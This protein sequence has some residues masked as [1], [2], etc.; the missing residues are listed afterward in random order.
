MTDNNTAVGVDALSSITSGT[1]NTSLGAE[2]LTGTSSGSENVAIGSQAGINNVS[3]SENVII[4]YGSAPTLTSGSSNIIIGAAADVPTASTSNYLN[5]GGV[6]T[7]DMSTGAVTLAD[8]FM[9]TT[10]SPLD[11]STKIATTAYVDDAVGASGTVTSVAA[12][13]TQGVTISGSPITSSGTITVGLGNITPT[14]VAASGTVT[15]SNLSG[16]NT[17]DQTITLTS[18]VTGSG[19][20]SFAT[21]IKSSVNLSGSPTTT[22]QSPLDDSTKIATTA[23]VDSAVA[24]GPGGTVTTTGSPSSGNLTKFSGPTSVTNGDLSGD[25][26]TSGTLATT[27]AAIQGTTVSGTTGTSKVVFSNSPTLVTPALGTPSSG[28][29]TNC[30]SLPVSTGISGL[31]AGVA[32]FLATPSSANLAAAVTGE[33]GSGGLVF[34]NS[35]SL[36]GAPTAPTQSPGD[37]STKI[38]TTAYVN[39]AVS[40]PKQRTIGFSAISPI[41]GQQGTFVVFPAIGTITGWSIVADAGT[42]TVKT[43]KIAAGTTAPTSANNIS[44]S[45]VSLATGTAV[46]S[47]IVT[48]FT[49]TAV[50]ANDIFAFN[51]TN[52]F[53]VTRLDFQL[54]ITES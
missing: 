52:V 1:D 48:D 19:T 28:T 20:G 16:T 12:S 42:A 3:G 40:N 4:G 18:D 43:W 23:Y 30:T 32:P 46:I 53:G 54:Q 37:N 9:A 51:L 38:A 24:A 31:G 27:V 21:T 36:T 7:G 8:G 17:G 6:I 41:A 22:T 15:G 50:S 44:T 34:A 25:V 29:L 11:S 14:S 5:I 2:A 26:T 45:G 10:Q 33:T 47:S 35:P 39:A 13:G 49:T